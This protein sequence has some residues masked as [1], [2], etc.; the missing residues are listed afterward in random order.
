MSEF[1]Y[2]NA[3]ENTY[4]SSETAAA[5]GRLPNGR[6]T[7]ILNEAR[8]YPPD[9]KKPYPRFSTSWVVTEGEYKGRFL[10]MNYNF[11]EQG[12]PYFKQFTQILGVDLPRLMELP[13][14]L[15]EFSGKICQLTLADQKNDPRYQ[16]TYLD[17]LLGTGRAAD[18]LKPRAA[19]PR[20]GQP[21]AAG[22]QPVE[23]D[24]GDI[25]F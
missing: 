17:R 5:G 19:A 22:Y 10:Y 2:L 3:L 9:E 11:N 7:A 25:P 18:Y 24:E 4:E 16:N 20:L 13:S 8:L 1:D 12:F 14:R 6:Y 21:D 15:G 23:S